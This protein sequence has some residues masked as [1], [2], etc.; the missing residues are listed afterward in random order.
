MVLGMFAGCF[1]AAHWANNV[2]LRLPQHPIRVVQA[3]GGGIITGFGAMACCG[4]R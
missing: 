2:K 3:L 1:S 4:S